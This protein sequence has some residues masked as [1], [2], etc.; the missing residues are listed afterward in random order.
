MLNEEI[1]VEHPT[2][3]HPTEGLRGF[4]PEIQE[5][6]EGN[7]C[8]DSPKEQDPLYRKLDDFID[9][10]SDEDGVLIRVLHYAQNLF[11]YLPR[12][13]QI[14][15]GKR[16]GKSL[17]E[18]YGVVSFYHYFTT[19]QKADYTIE[20]CM[21][22]ACYVKGASAIISELEKELG[23]KVGQMTK[24]HHFGLKVSRCIGACGLAPVM[25]IGKDIHGRLTPEM[26]PEIL[27]RYEKPKES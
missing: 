8:C 17:A 23:I 14:H 1:N 16:L 19:E 27:K 15:I 4:E 5:S 24:D 18:V 6:S 12:E 21:G 10:L 25:V 3:E 13:V 20:A 9:S 11:G 7:C 26:I 22:T 2:V